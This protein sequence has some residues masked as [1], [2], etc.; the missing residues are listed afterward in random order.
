MYTSRVWGGGIWKVE[1]LGER[2]LKIE[3]IVKL[4]R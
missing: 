1:V 4:K 3:E 2:K